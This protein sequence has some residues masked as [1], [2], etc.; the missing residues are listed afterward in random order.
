MAI[1]LTD[2]KEVFITKLNLPTPRI[3]VLDWNQLRLQALRTLFH[4]EGAKTFQKG[5]TSN[6][7]EAT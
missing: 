2:H 7:F 5:A 6:P 1:S 4:I 3:L